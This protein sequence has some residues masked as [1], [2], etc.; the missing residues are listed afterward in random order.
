MMK[1]IKDYVIQ[2]KHIIISIICV[3]LIFL[4]IFPYAKSASYS[5]FVSDDFAR[6]IYLKG[7]EESLHDHIRLAIDLLKANYFQKGGYYTN[8]LSIAVLSPINILNIRGLGFVMEINVWAYYL[9]IVFLLYNILRMTIVN[10]TWGGVICVCIVY[11]LTEYM[12]MQESFY[13]LTSALAYTFPAECILCGI[14]CFLIYVRTKKKW[15][16]VLGIILGIIGCGG[17]LNVPALGCSL[18]LLIL[19]YYYLKER[20]INI[21]Y[22][23]WFAIWIVFSLVNTLAPGNYVRHS[24]IDDTGLH[25]IK[26]VFGAF[27]RVYKKKYLNIVSDTDLLFVLLLLLLCGYFI[28][29]KESLNQKYYACISIIAL[30]VPIIVAYPLALGYNSLDPNYALP[31][32]VGQIIDLSLVLSLGNAAICVGQYIK[33]ITGK[34]IKLVATMF[35]LGIFIISGLDNYSIID[36]NAS[37][38]IYR[39]L[40]SGVYKNYNEKVSALL[41]SLRQREGEDVVVSCDEYPEPIEEFMCLDLSSPDT[42]DS[43][44]IAE[45]YGLKSITI[46]KTQ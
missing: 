31:R 46:E 35:I 33:S 30:L 38:K 19:I 40:N 23:V 2:K 8:I 4:M 26:A 41:D 36:N 45:F 16:Y 28:V 25:P 5:V 29:L 24:K 39:A 1:H 18:I 17:N 37:I 14:S 34:N 21:D 3:F 43:I 12:Q 44:G 27:M 32:R 6:A 15:V 13:W 10:R 20:N 7:S 11:L 9:S 22:M 42:Q